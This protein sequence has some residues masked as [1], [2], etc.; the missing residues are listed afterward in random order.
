M[1][2]DRLSTLRES[3]SGLM[4]RSFETSVCSANPGTLD[5]TQSKFSI[6]VESFYDRD[7]FNAQSEK[8][9]RSKMF[10]GSRAEE[11]RRAD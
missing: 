2:L 4:T 5:M 3:D 9:S 6:L 7:G 8:S 11:R 10:G 1:S